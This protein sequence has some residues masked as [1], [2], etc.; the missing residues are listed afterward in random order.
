MHRYESPVVLITGAGR[1]GR[2]GADL[3]RSFH[4]R[5]YNVVIHYGES[6]S[7]ADELCAELNATRENSAVILQGNLL[8]DDLDS[9]APHLITEAAKSWRRLDVLINSASLFLMSPPGKLSLRD[10]ERLMRINAHAPYLLMQAFAAYHQ[11]AATQGKVFNISDAFIGKDH[12]EEL[13]QYNASKLALEKFTSDAAHAYKNLYVYGM[14]PGAML[15]PAGV[16]SAN[17]VVQ[18]EGT[19]ELK[20]K[21]FLFLENTD[22]YDIHKGK[23]QPCHKGEATY[24][25]DFISGLKM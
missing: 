3:A 22:Y 14:A 23:T 1:K 24:P 16:V 18:Y 13:S 17:D 8:S 2:V 21:I 6:K 5:N 15:H 10:G 9:L 11:A 25:K 4:Q 19:A 12:S 7:D 20:R